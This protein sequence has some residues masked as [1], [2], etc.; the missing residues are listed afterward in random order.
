MVLGNTNAQLIEF[1]TNYRKKM[2]TNYYCPPT[3]LLIASL[4]QGSILAAIDLE[5]HERDSLYELAPIDAGTV[6]RS[7]RLG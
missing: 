1:K 6:T 5:L 4:C 3:E 7:L 2:K